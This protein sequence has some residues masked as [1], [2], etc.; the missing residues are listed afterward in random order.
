MY[1][2]GISYM[3]GRG[4]T[5]NT[6][7]GI[8]YLTAAAEKNSVEACEVLAKLY[9]DGIKDYNGQSSFGSLSDAEVYA[10]NL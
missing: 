10:K 6:D 4:I 9:R 2:L 8:Q 3:D 1:E 5:K 7:K